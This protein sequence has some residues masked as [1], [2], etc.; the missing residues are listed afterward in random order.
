ME[1]SPVE[2]GTLL[3]DLQVRKLVVT[4]AGRH[5]GPGGLVSLG[6]HNKEP[7]TGW[8]KTR[9]THTVLGTRSWNQC[10][11]GWFLLEAVRESLFCASLLASGVLGDPWCS[12]TWRC[13]LQSLPSSLHGHLFPVGLCV[14]PWHSPLSV[15]LSSSYRD[16]SHIGLRAHPA[17]VWLILI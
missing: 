5:A 17:L 15:S 11:Q 6:C 13:S 1:S 4:E 8:R 7:Y 3:W 10:Q 2:P 14:F 9:E 16:T 12:L